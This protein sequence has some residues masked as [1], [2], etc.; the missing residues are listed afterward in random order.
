MN[1]SKDIEF[2]ILLEEMKKI[3]RQTKIIGSN[4]RE[5]DAEHS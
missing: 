4:R 3:N 2:V 5:N 1:I